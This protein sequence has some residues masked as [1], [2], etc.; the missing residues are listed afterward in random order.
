[1]DATT[2]EPLEHDAPPK[3][4]PPAIGDGEATAAAS[5]LRYILALAPAELE[6]P[7]VC[8]RALLALFRLPP[9]SRL[10]ILVDLSWRDARRY[11]AL[12]DAVDAAV[13]AG[14]IAPVAELARVV[15][16]HDILCPDRRRRI[17][18]LLWHV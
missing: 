12:I 4:T 1:M 18:R 3:P 8:E 2:S 9:R 16:L 6:R 7:E 13:Q 15:L 14:A 17:D 11:A 10:E 5:L